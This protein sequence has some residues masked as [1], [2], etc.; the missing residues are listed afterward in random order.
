LRSILGNESPDYF[1]V[2]FDIIVCKKLTNLADAGS[3]QLRV[4]MEEGVALAIQ[5]FE[6]LPE[7][8]FDES[9]GVRVRFVKEDGATSLRVT[10][11][12]LEVLD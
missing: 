1:H 5:R 10:H 8:T 9:Q 7:L 11:C 2:Q 12:F 4:R 3:V 6:G